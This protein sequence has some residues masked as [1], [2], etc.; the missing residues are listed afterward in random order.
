MGCYLERVRFVTLRGGGNRGTDGHLHVQRHV[1]VS[2]ATSADVEE[3]S[4]ESVE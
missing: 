2:E 3:S 4:S 1:S